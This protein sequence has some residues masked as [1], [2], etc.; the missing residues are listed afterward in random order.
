[1][2][3][4]IKSRKDPTATLNFLA[5][6][7][8]NQLQCEHKQES[9]MNSMQSCTYT[10]THE[11]VHEL[12]GHLQQ[13]EHRLSYRVV[14]CACEHLMHLVELVPSSEIAP[15]LNATDPA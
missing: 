15:F 4:V 1:M 3:S 11:Q 10:H 12:V 13:K 7:A 5:S 8:S 14:V 6:S 2:V 9:G